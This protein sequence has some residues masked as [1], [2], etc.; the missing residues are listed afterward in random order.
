MHLEY[1]ENIVSSFGVSDKIQH[2]PL[3]VYQET[4][5]DLDEGWGF[6][7]YDYELQFRPLQLRR[8]RASVWR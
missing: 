3:N 6:P 8:V 5:P 2:S 7:A 4:M 1:R